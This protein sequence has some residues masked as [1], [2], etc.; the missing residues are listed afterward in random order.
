MNVTPPHYRYRVSRLALTCAALFTMLCAFGAARTAHADPDPTQTTG[1][2]LVAH[3]P[4]T[5]TTD[6]NT[7]SQSIDVQ[8]PKLVD[9]NKFNCGIPGV[10][11]VSS[12][13][14]FPIYLRVGA[15]LTPRQKFDVGVD[16][17]IPGLHILPSLS[18]RI[19]ADAIL[20][21]NFGGV[22]SLFP[23]TIDQIYTKRLVGGTSVYLGGGV[24]PYFGGTTRFGGK[25]VAGVMFNGY[26]LEGALHF[27]G[28]GDSLLTLQARFG[29]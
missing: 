4:K 16:A 25:V 20:S 5:K 29:L 3:L 26:G 23:L 9:M 21:A 7:A 28:Q 18:T 10:P 11:G 15:L 14:P 13:N 19:D 12:L 8:T 1:N 6:T 17:T 22:S 27:S 24:G 2:V